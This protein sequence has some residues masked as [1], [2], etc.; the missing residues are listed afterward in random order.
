MA[1]AGSIAVSGLCDIVRAWP[2]CAPDGDGFVVT[3]HCQLPNGSLVKVRIRPAGGGQW[4]ASDG[5]AALDEAV[6]S[7]VEI[8]TFNLNIRRAIRS[9]GLSFAEGRI[10]SPRVG[11]ESLFN[12]TVVVANAARDIAEALL[13]IGG[14]LR[15]EKLERRA[16]AILVSKFHSWVLAKPVTIQGASERA[17][18]FRNAL[19]LPDGR[20][21]L[22][23][24]VK[25]QGNSINSAV[26]SNLDV[27]RLEDPRIVQR[28]VFDPDEMWKPEEIALLEVG[29]IPIALPS[30]A[31]AITR[32]AA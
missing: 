14:D 22:I 31:Q 16:R 11:T 12:A 6:A 27:R 5:G 25:H 28:I 10:E 21:V 30:L 26:V 24:V 20:R 4:I 18:R 1:T 8:P 2:L 23:D 13:M 15:E 29:A 32:I 17:H 7:G 3:T 19:N 9:K